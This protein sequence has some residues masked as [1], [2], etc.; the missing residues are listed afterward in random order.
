MFHRLVV[1]ACLR[2]LT[3]VVGKQLD[4]GFSTPSQY[5]A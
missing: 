1:P 3:V 5:S 4:H 2:H